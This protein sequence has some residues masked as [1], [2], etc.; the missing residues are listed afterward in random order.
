MQHYMKIVLVGKDGKER[1]VVMPQDRVVLARTLPEENFGPVQEKMERGVEVSV[2]VA[3]LQDLGV[4]K[5]DW[6]SRTDICCT[7]P[8]G[9]LWMRGSEPT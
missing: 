9:W 1:R 5:K 7:L 6:F 4:V 8:E 3:G 2:V